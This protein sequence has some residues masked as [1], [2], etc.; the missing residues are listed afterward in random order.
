MCSNDHSKLFR[1]LMYLRQKTILSDKDHLLIGFSKKFH[2]RSNVSKKGLKSDF[3]FNLEPS[4]ITFKFRVLFY[5]PDPNSLQEYT[6][7]GN[8]QLGTKSTH[9]DSE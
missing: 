2:D 8:F 1:S 9:S 3:I 7:Y 6:R 4:K 5:T